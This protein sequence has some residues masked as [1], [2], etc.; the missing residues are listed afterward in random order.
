MK[1]EISI[2][3]LIEQYKLIKN[4]CGIM[5]DDYENISVSFLF[6]WKKAFSSDCK[7]KNE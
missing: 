6:V 1:M 4:L 2:G 3:Y 5:T 7:I